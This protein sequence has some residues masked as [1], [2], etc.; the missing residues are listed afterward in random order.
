MSQARIGVRKRRKREQEKLLLKAKHLSI[1]LQSEAECATHVLV[2][3][4]IHAAFIAL[5]LGQMH[6]Q[7]LEPGYHSW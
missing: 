3:C 4:C 7:S 1:D 2:G 6:P 5:V